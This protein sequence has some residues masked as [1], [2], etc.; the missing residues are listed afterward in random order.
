MAVCFRGPVF[1]EAWDRG[2]EVG[3]A[4]DD[5]FGA[6]LDEGFWGG[7]LDGRGDCEG[8]RYC[9]CVPHG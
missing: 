7:N 5:C 2:E 1:E 6:L 8:C 9:G 3:R 4:V